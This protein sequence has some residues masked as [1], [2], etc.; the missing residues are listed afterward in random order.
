MVFQLFDFAILKIHKN[1]NLDFF[2]SLHRSVDNFGFLIAGVN[3]S[4]VVS[5]IML[6]VLCCEYL[7]HIVQEKIFMIYVILF[8][9]SDSYNSMFIS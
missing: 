3:G 1:V 2:N 4:Y 6:R 8:I 5:M 9:P 7:I